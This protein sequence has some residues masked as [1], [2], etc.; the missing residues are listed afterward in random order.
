M[1]IIQQPAT[2]TVPYKAMIENLDE[3]ADSGGCYANVDYLIAWTDRFTFA[4]QV[5]GMSQ[6][7]G[8]VSGAWIQNLPFQYPASPNLWAMSL[9][10]K[11]EGKPTA[12]PQGTPTYTNAI[13]S[14]NFRKPPFNFQSSDDPSGFNSFAVTPQESQ[15]LQWASQEIDQ[16]SEYIPLPKTNLKWAGDSTSVD[17]PVS[18]KVSHQVMTIVYDRFPVLPANVLQSYQDTLNKNTFFNC[19]PGTVMFGGA[20]TRREPNPDGSV[21]QKLAITL[22]YRAQDHNMMIKSTG[23]GAGS[24]DFVI[25]PT[26]SN[27]RLFQYADFLGL[28]QWQPAVLSNL[29]G[30]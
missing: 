3:G 15:Y 25:D 12:N 30:S 14:V 10:M 1:N 17:Q 28:L 23:A 11:G 5:M 8:G 19:A 29:P 16:G 24:W 18:R 2:I 22:K 20:K 27:S 26:N 13:V 4:N 6:S 21:C 7:A 9:R